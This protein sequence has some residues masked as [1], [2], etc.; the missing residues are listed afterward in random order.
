M[1]GQQQRRDGRTSSRLEV[2]DRR[3]RHYMPA[4]GQHSS[5]ARYPGAMPCS[6]RLIAGNSWFRAT[7]IRSAS[8]SFSRF[9]A[10]YKFVCMYVCMYVELSR[11]TRKGHKPVDLHHW[12]TVTVFYMVPTALPLKILICHCRLKPAYSACITCTNLLR[13]T[14][15]SAHP[16]TISPIY[17]NF[18]VF[19]F[20]L[21]LYF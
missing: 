13:R 19:M 20:H 21:K 7:G 16:T 12:Q 18:N 15:A 4:R 6:A 8:D 1:N 17:Y 10:L 14:K 9:L 5:S 3:Q 11:L 2:D